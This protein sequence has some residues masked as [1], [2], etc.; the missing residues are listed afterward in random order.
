MASLWQK[1]KTSH[2]DN[3]PAVAGALLYNAHHKSAGRVPVALADLPEHERTRWI[4]RGVRA[5]EGI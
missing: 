4:E 5:L 2:G 1:V 3:A